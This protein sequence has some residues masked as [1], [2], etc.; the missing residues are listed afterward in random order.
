E[1]QTIGYVK[2]PS[3]KSE[4][5]RGSHDMTGGGTSNCVDFQERLRPSKGDTNYWLR[6]NSFPQIR[7]SGHMTLVEV[8]RV[9]V[10][11]SKN[12]YALPK[13]IQTIG[14]VKIPSRK[15]EF[16]RGSHDMTGGG[17]SNCVDF[18]ERL[19]PS[20][21]DTNYWLRENSFP[22]IGILTRVT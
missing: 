1:I 8:A 12:V 7:N 22:Q 3:R 16:L 20:K 19:R 18:Q 9:I 5:L 4:F 17:T 6:G 10:S 2:I 11:I 21:G 14:Y 13:E 15:S